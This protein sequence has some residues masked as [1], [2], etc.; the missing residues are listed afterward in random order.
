MAWCGGNTKDIRNNIADRGGRED[1]LLLFNLGPGS[2]G[3]NWEY[4]F[5]RRLS[6]WHQKESP[7]R[8]PLSLSNEKAPTAVVS[9]AKQI[10]AP[11]AQHRMGTAIPLLP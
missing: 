7:R 9:D 8:E 6:N 10:A 2:D 4:F 5:P 3:S 11:L 1:R